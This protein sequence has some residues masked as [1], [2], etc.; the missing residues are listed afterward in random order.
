MKIL[1][2]GLCGHMGREVVKLTE[3]G[4]RNITLAAGV[5]AFAEGETPVPCAK[6]FAEADK[7]VD[8]VVDFSHHSLTHEL[9]DFAVANDL[10]VVLATTGQT[11]EEK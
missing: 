2:S 11:A 3:A 10:P 7:N 8:C 1:L 5:D 9:M 6:S 4:Y